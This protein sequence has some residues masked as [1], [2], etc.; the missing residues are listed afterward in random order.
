MKTT[1]YF[2]AHLDDV[3]SNNFEQAQRLIPSEDL[4]YSNE[5]RHARGLETDRHATVFYS[6]SE[7]D[8]I[9][10]ANLQTVI[11]HI[12]NYSLTTFE[13]KSFSVEDV[14]AFKNEEFEAIV[15]KTN[16]ESISTLNS[17]VS[18]H[19]GHYGIT[20]LHDEFKQHVTIAYVKVGKSDELIEKLK[21]AL[22]DTS[23]IARSIKASKRTVEIDGTVLKNEIEILIK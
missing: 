8:H 17:L 2:G 21:D 15:A 4:Y 11:Q 13:N 19:L 9:D 22:T 16:S 1:Y 14:F 18:E 7:T 12:L 20:P 23:F 5:M 6:I 3:S 10:I